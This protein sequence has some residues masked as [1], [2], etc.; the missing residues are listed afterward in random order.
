MTKQSFVQIN[1]KLYPKGHEPLPSSHYIMG[2]IKPYKSQVTGEMIDGRSQHRDHLR[3]HNM[4]EVGNETKALMAMR[5]EVK[6]DD[7]RRKTI[8][9]IL[10][11]RRNGR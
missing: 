1:G 6:R 5:P 3:K 4:F 2:D 11:G 7:S 10:Q 9:A 8:A